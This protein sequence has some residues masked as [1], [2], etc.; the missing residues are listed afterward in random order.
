MGKGDKVKFEVAKH[1][2]EELDLE[3]QLKLQDLMLEYF[4]VDMHALIEGTEGA[5]SE[6]FFLDHEDDCQ[7]CPCCGCTCDEDDYDFLYPAEDE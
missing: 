1:E 3:D 4:G 5:P 6:T 2:W 7:C